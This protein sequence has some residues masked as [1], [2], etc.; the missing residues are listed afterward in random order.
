MSMV[1]DPCEVKCQLLS[2]VVPQS[3]PVLLVGIIAKQPT[4]LFNLRPFS[5]NKK[6]LLQILITGTCVFVR[7]IKRK[8]IYSSLYYW[9]CNHKVRGLFIFKNFAVL[10]HDHSTLFRYFTF[11]SLLVTEL[12][13]NVQRFKNTVCSAINMCRA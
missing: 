13:V 5:I 12:V 1:F 8:I 11:S 3:Q 4:T 10:P 9:T 6:E 2:S 7:Y